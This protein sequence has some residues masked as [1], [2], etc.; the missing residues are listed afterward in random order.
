MI[1]ELCDFCLG[2]GA[3]ELGQAIA[4]A[5]PKQLVNWNVFPPF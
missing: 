5:I 1:Y 4:V 2:T 3:S